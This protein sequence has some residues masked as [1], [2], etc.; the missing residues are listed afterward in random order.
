MRRSFQ[1]AAG[2]IFLVFAAAMAGIEQLLL[3]P[4][5]LAFGWIKSLGRFFSAVQLTPG[6]V[7]WFGIMAG[8]LV[9]GTHAFCT[10]VRRVRTSAIGAWRWKW[11]CSFYAAL[12]LV[13]FA[14]AALVGVAHQTGWMILS[15]EPMFRTGKEA[16]A[17]R[18]RL[19]YASRAVFE[20]AQTNE[21]DLV[22]VKR[23]M[24]R[25]PFGSNWEDF[26]FYF[27]GATNGSTERLIL[28]QRNP[29]YQQEI[30]IVERDKLY[31][32]PFQDLA[33]LLKSPP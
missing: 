29:K 27:V 33:G 6:T 25:L 3:I 13:L 12:V 22:R 1:I 21:W 4:L 7:A 16:M 14:S 9:L 32:R 5:T 26:A 20:V 19:R 10:S 2:L 31:T 17:D 24:A 18:T 11:T 15:K 30:G 28:L 8:V 23:E